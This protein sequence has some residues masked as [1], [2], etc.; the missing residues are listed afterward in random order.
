MSQQ[1]LLSTA[2]RALSYVHSDD[3]D[4][5]VRMGAALKDE[6]GDDAL[7]IWLNWSE[8]SDTFSEKSALA[9]WRSFKGG[10]GKN[11][12]IGSLFKAAKS[13]GFS[14]ESAD[15]SEEDP[16]EREKR[17]QE[18][19]E[20]EA[21]AAK[22]RQERAGAAARRAQS[23]WRSAE[24]YGSSQYLERKGVVAEACRFLKDGALI[25]PVM[26]Y[27]RERAE[28]VGKQQIAADGS[29]KF[30]SG[31]EKSGAACRLGEA[32][33]DGGIIL[34]G[35]G[36]ATGLSCRMAVDHV[37]PFFVAFDAGNLIHVAQVLR[38]KY[39]SSPIL[40]CADDDYL[41]KHKG[42]EKAREAAAAVGYAGVVLPKFSI[43]RRSSKNDEA[44]PLLTDFNDLH[45]AQ[46]LEVVSEQL[47]VAIQ[48][49]ESGDSVVEPD[50]PE[51]M[52]V[53]MGNS[54]PFPPN[55]EPAAPALDEGGR[56]GRKKE[57][58]P[59]FWDTVEHLLENF[60]LVYGEDYAWD[61]Q[62]RIL[63]RIANMRLAFSSDV[64]KFWL[65]NPLRKMVDKA[66]VV[67]SPAMGER[68]GYVN[69]YDGIK[70]QPKVG[71]FD[72]ILELLMHLCS[73]DADLADWVASWMA[74][75]L[76]NPG[77]KM[78]SSII[79]HGDEG[80]GKNL[81]FE[82]VLGRIYGEYAGVIG[83]AQ[84]EGSFNEWASRKLYMVADEV[85]TRAELRQLKGRL[86]Q[87]VTG[88]VVRINAKMQSERDEANHMNFVFLS[89]ELQPLALDKTDRRYLVLWT[90]PKLDESFY[91]AVGEELKNGGVEA[92]YH[93]LLDLRLDGFNEHS[94]PPLN[95]A[96]ENLISLG[97]SPVERFYRE[98][99]EGFLP[100]PFIC[101]T[102]DQIFSAYS[103]WCYLNGER[104]PGTKTSFGRNLTRTGA[105]EL[106]KA[107]I[108]FDLASDVRQRTV[109][110]VGNEPLDRARKDWVED[111]SNT[112]AT[113]LNKYRPGGSY[114][115]ADE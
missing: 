58:P 61:A 101:C 35:E 64:V 47:G 29:K 24:R 88:E 56:G 26:R 28:M 22:A 12:G 70:M 54:S 72:R 80:S 85:V 6:Y 32:P 90:P 113:S 46:G 33:V 20:K 110:L 89:N 53:D 25:L 55:E 43:E 48:A 9:V 71:K 96:K 114:G 74:Y 5:W 18:R 14:F 73:G 36:Y 86:K 38:G 62:K 107:V 83:N 75:P 31:M 23:Q 3:R 100:L 30:S 111:A 40:I 10:K 66:N 115:P 21:A 51:Y 98:W 97:L 79:V 78:R 94:K 19:A 7:Q 65:Q 15:F 82:S 105:G 68:E 59:G 37:Y 11:I 39:P 104:W 67:F 45:V 81:L 91:K 44:L 69:L 60:T 92:F 41:T 42:D 52:D 76:Q 112:F 16:I 1:A 77:A 103:R 27:D 34:L 102:A 93:Y 57:F 109:Y 95:E 50:V 4:T 2:Q 49:L 108:K 8:G 63:I 13:N 106:R 87:L 99:R 17:R 84:I